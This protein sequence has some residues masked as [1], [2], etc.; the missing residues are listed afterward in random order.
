MGAVEL[1]LRASTI[2]NSPAVLDVF[3]L[4][5]GVE[6]TV[7]P[8]WKVDIHATPILGAI[9]NKARFGAPSGGGPEQVL[10]VRGTALMGGVEIKN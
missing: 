5:G 8:E 9:E 1:D 6:I 10:T 7:P 2:A 4:W 3:A